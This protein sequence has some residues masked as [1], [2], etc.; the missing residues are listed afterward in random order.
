VYPVA[1]AVPCQVPD[2][3][4]P[5]VAKEDADVKL[6]NVSIADSIVD[7]VVASKASIL[8]KVAVPEES[9]RMSV[10]SIAIP[11]PVCKSIPAS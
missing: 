11:I 8:L 6:P 2:D 7:S 9:V 3:I 10:P 5:T 4:V 1:T